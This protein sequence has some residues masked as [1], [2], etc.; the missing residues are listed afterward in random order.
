MNLPPAPQAYS[1]DDQQNC[2]N[3]LRTADMQ[4]F[5]RGRDVR[6]QAGERI[7]LTAPDGGLWAITVDNAGALGTDGPL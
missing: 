3:Q 4:N 7:I 1:K 5:K 6:L 2:R